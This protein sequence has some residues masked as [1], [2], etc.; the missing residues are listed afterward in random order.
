MSAAI[1]KLVAVMAH[2]RSK[3]GGC[4]WDLE[5]NFK[6]IAPYTLE[7][8]YEVVEAIEKNDPKALAEELGDLLFQVIFYAQMGSEEGLF[9]LES[10]AS[11]VADKMVERHP[12]VFGDRDA[13]SSDAVLMNWEKDKAAK[14]EAEAGGKPVSALDGVTTALPATTRALKLQNRAACVGFD[15][16]DAH[17]ILA[18]IKEEIGELEELEMDDA[19]NKDAQEDEFGDL[20]FAIINLARRLDVDPETAL[21]RTNRKFETRFRSIETTITSQGKRMEDTSLDEM[22]RLWVGVKKKEKG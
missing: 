12:H 20:F 3:D 1:D 5:Q 2:L 7:E 6:T 13:K 14:R 9:D 4:P 8:T 15:W 16:T 18:K 11:K 21:R 19:K 17:D 10:I 22:E